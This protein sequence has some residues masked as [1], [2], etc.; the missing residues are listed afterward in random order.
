MMSAN[1]LSYF[2]FFIAL[3]QVIVV[4]SPVLYVT[5]RGVEFSAYMASE[6]VNSLKLSVII[7]V[8][9]T[10]LILLLSIPIGYA[11]SRE[12]ASV[13]R[14]FFPLLLLFSAMSPAAV[15]LIL[16]MF[17]SAVP[18]GA[19]LHQA[20]GIVNNWKGILV[21]QLFIGLPLGISFFASIFST[22]PRSLEET[23]YTM[24][25]SREELLFKAL[26]PMLRGEVIM[27][28][29]TVFARVFG[30]FGASFILGGGIRGRTVTL[31]I[32]LY[33]AYQTG[34]LSIASFVLI[35]YIA[36]S[37]SIL[38]LLSALYIRGERIAVGA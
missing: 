13:R 5:Y 24:G 15:G 34:E 21:A 8:A 37:L 38:A 33:Y 14:A 26:V 27:G 36:S 23:G 22:V 30:D 7:S 35:A 18:I 11:L 25:Y 6:L 2:V 17:F 10:S 1:R 29:I 9:S 28:F 12:R 20:L 19:L 32:F 31:P 4:I 16:L 3:V